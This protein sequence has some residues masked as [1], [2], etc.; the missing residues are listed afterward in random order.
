MIQLVAI[1]MDGTCLNKYSRIS[2][3]NLEA[4]RR[5]K[6]AGIL[7]VP[8]TGRA[9]DCLPYQL[10]EQSDLYSYVITSNGAVVRDVR[11]KKDIFRKCIP[12]YMAQY[13]L[14]ECENEKV[15]VTA[16]VKNE[17]WIQGN[18]LRL[19]GN[20]FFGKDV[21]SAKKVNNIHQV[22]SDQGCS[23]EEI[24]LYF[25]PGAKQESIRTILKRYPELNAAYTNLY[26]EI[27]SR[28]TSKGNALRQLAKMLH[29]DSSQIACIGDGENDLSMFKE[30]GLKIAMANAVDVLKEQADYIVD[31]NQKD[32][33][34]QAIDTYILNE[35]KVEE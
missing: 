4:L 21:R 25:L 31:C 9:L 16:H 15:G 14:E 23:V 30:A 17:Y 6:E 27:Y 10:R 11:L 26:V 20:V 2:K 34:A 1:D 22:I 33:V 35:K 19:A 24:Q 3:A 5:A 18:A 29:I 32:G 8:T 13:L 12:D 7:I 28:G